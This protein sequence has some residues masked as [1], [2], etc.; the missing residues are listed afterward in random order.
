VAVAAIVG[1][2]AAASVGLLTTD[3]IRLLGQKADA[4]GSPLRKPFGYS[5]F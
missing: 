4:G 1:C 5:V 3:S 2:E